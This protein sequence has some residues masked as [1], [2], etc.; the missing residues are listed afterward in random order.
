MSMFLPRSLTFRQVQAETNLISTSA[1]AHAK[2]CFMVNP[3]A[4]RSQS[5]SVLVLWGHTLPQMTGLTFSKVRLVLAGKKSKQRADTWHIYSNRLSH[6]LCSRAWP[7][8]GTTMSR[9]GRQGLRQAP[10]WRMSPTT[11]SL[12]ARL[13][14]GLRA[15][16]PTMSRARPAKTTFH[17]ATWSRSITH[18]INRRS[19]RASVLSCSPFSLSCEAPCSRKS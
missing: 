11:T 16:C 14:A 8:A 4:G 1:Y 5:R 13:S 3:K 17:V 2:S 15:F 19:L 6:F 9:A 7:L 10:F 18:G 12:W